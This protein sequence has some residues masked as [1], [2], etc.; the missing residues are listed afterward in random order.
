VP[1]ITMCLNTD[2][3]HLTR[4]SNTDGRDG[5]WDTGR[6]HLHIDKWQPGWI[7]AVDRVPEFS[8]IGHATDVQF[9]RRVPQ[10]GTIH[11]DKRAWEA[12]QL[13]LV[14]ILKTTPVAI[15]ITDS[16]QDTPLPLSCQDNGAN[17]QFTM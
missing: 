15:G 12:C 9:L 3:E 4:Y 14:G 10:T 5:A 11:I 1:E 2:M 17:M 6:H 13:W 8:V 16:V 7:V